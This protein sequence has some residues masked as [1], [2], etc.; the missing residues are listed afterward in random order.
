MAISLTSPD[1]HGSGPIEAATPSRALPRLAHLR[2]LTGPAPL[3]HSEHCELVV[4]SVESPDPHG[5][6]PIEA[7]IVPDWARVNEH[8]RT[9]TGPAPL[10]LRKRSACA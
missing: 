1:P 8:L 10:K 7:E 9:L 3:K 2:T 5:S 6:G 4:K